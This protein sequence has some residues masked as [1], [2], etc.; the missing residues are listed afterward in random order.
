MTIVQ[1]IGSAGLGTIVLRPLPDVQP[2]S[3]QSGYSF[4]GI[5]SDMRT[6]LR[7][8][9]VP[10]LQDNSAAA[11][12][13]QNV[14]TMID[15][16]N[17][18]LTEQSSI[19]TAALN[20]AVNEVINADI[21]VA[22]PLILAVLNA[23][24]SQTR[25]WLHA[26]FADGVTAPAPLGNGQDDTAALMAVIAPVHVIGGT[27]HLQSG[28][29]LCNLDFNPQFPQVRLVGKG[30]RATTLQGFTSAKPVVKFNG[31]SGGIGGGGIEHVRITS[32]AG[33][34]NGIALAFSGTTGCEAR[35]VKIDGAFS[36]GVRFW[37][38]R[39]DATQGD[40]TELNTFE[41]DIS[42]CYTPIRYQVDNTVESFHGSGVVGNT[43]INLPADSTNAV[44]EIDKNGV[45][46]NAPM[47]FTVWFQAAGAKLFR[48][49]SQ[50]RAAGRG[51]SF[52]G[53]IR[54]EGHPSASD[55]DMA[56]S[57]GNLCY[58]MYAGEIMWLGSGSMRLGR[59][60]LC[61]KIAYEGG[62][63][64]F[65]PKPISSFATLKNTPTVVADGA[66]FEAASISLVAV[67]VQAPGYEFHAV[68]LVQRSQ[69]DGSQAS[70]V[71]IGRTQDLDS[72]N[73]GDPQWGFNSA[74]YCTNANFT[75]AFTCY[76][77]VTALGG[78]P[79]HNLL[80]QKR[81]G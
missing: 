32:A 64:W 10:Y 57:D 1:P 13:Q 37:N 52:Y 26:H 77:T 75:P 40:F 56:I 54:C 66:Y 49:G 73:V 69:F 61:N 72:N 78:G 24:S 41:G 34:S 42:G 5:L 6:W 18:A 39:G 30:M 47:S 15:T 62:T 11:I 35:R 27:V 25:D 29:Y 2:F 53:T 55:S 31:G 38:E 80:S 63:V 22:D 71:E 46:Y 4:E 44:V 12:F 14:D 33:T 48:I 7:D 74:L 70:I 45:P 17:K 58:V 16:V 23:V 68:L 67:T 20:A 9:L 81:F 51:V 28:T 59:L 8:V 65:E 21:P 43:T 76:V 19:V 60:M 36:E 3:I 79:L 50:A